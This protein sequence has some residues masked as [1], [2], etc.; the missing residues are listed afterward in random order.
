[1]TSLSGCSVGGMLPHGPASAW[2][3]GTG[4]GSLHREC[5]G[6]A[7]IRFNTN[8]LTLDVS[9]GWGELCA[10]EEEGAVGGLEVDNR[11]LLTF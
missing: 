4:P 2:E 7:E 1:M 11:C 8:H 9:E 10:M 3:V 5:W 6:R